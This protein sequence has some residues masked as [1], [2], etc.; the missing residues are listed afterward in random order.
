MQR[1]FIPQKLFSLSDAVI[2]VL[3][4]TGIYGMVA[5][6]HAWGTSFHAATNID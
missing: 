6:G 2:L 4:G 5:I 1:T 3:I